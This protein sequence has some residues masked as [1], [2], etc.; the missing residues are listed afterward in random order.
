MLWRTMPALLL[1]FA[2][3]AFIAA[4]FAVDVVE[5]GLVMRF[6]RVVRVV[7]EPGLHVKAPFDRIVRLDNRVLFLRPAR[8][9][10]LT[11]DKK[12]IVVES[13][14]T[15][16]I[17]GP[18]RFLATLATR[19]AAEERLSD[20]VLGEIGSVMGRYPAS[21]LISTD[22]AESRYRAI[23][24]EIG[25]GVA[26]FARPVYGIEVISVDLLRLSLPEQNREH[27]FDRMKAERA[28]I[29]KE[30][31][32]AGEL[33]AKKIIAEADHEKT[34]IDSEAAGQAER[35]RA[36][37]DATASATYAAAFGQDPKFY[38][39]LRTLRA[40]DKLLDDK[41]TLFLPADADVLRM[42]RFNTPPAPG[43]PSPSAPARDGVAASPP[44]SGGLPAGV[45]LLL[46]KKPE[47]GVR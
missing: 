36:E 15:W 23:L 41:T 30:N 11:N 35:I 37:G 13:L 24:S 29:A 3:W 20:I 8:S 6:G 25:R 22:P 17:A 34:R 1:A 33:E 7:E 32:S 28:K 12:N 26:D 21:A 43:E 42:L 19:A 16:R 5:Y 31:R 10:Y 45:D 44:V 27:V 18:E 40:Y 38:E 47:E 9:E 39:F 14:A 46:N 4:F 2:V